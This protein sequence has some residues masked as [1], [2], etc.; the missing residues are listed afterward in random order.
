MHCWLSQRLQVTGLV[1]KGTMIQWNH[2]S[3]TEHWENINQ[4]KAKVI[5]YL[6]LIEDKTFYND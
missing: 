6:E 4:M 2:I 1:R 3:S 5:K